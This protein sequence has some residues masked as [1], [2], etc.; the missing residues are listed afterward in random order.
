MLKPL[1]RRFY[2]ANDLR[3]SLYNEL[4]GTHKRR[5]KSTNMLH[6]NQTNLRFARL[7]PVSCILVA[8]FLSAAANAATTTFRVQVPASTPP[9]STVYIAGNF[10]GWNP[11]SPTH[12]LALQPDTRWEITLTF[13]DGVPIQFKFT[14]GSWATVEKGPNGEEIANRNHTPQGTQTLNLIVA[15]WADQPPSTITG[16]VESFQYAPFLNGRRCWVY[17]PQEY[18]Q[19]T[20]RY[21]VLYMHDG[22]NLFDQFTSFAGEWKID[23]TC[24]LLIA[25]REIEPI[26]VVGI[27]NSA[28]R[29]T[30]Y[31]P[32]PSSPP[33]GGC[34]GGGANT[35]L[36]AIRDVLIPEVNQRYRTR[37]GPANTYM[38]GSSLGG[39]ITA[40]AGYAYDEVWGRIGAVSPSYWWANDSMVNFASA[41]SRP[42]FLGRFY[43]DM[44]TQESGFTDQNGNGIDDYIDDLRSL[45]DVAL[46]QGF[47]TNVDF[48]SVEGPGHTHNEFYWALRAPDMLRFLIDPCPPHTPGDVNGDSAVN[49]SD[50]APFIAVLLSPPTATAAR[51]CT[52]NINADTS[53]NMLDVQPFVDLLLAE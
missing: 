34:A 53:V 48:L 13:P 30:E 40:Y 29:C 32:W 4:F 37:T 22:Q 5:A 8:I 41:Q 18:S 25:N 51:F 23:E 35:Y 21:P 1:Y 6:T 3:E 52:A 16:H 36:Q 27:E 47:V 17:L 15:N 12:A 39:L 9:G 49:G 11:G 26:I 38:S 19:T 14:R 2:H 50:I 42:P 24:E 45:R 28:A 20:D 44:G 10:Q 43:Q 31:T 7:L 46:A 33:I